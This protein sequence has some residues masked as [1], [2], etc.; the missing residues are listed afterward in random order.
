MGAVEVGGWRGGE[1][2]ENVRAG[3]GWRRPSEVARRSRVATPP[4][5]KRVLA[6]LQD[7]LMDGGQRNNVGKGK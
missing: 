1:W 3:R 5:G 2:V 6:P 7:T 4:H